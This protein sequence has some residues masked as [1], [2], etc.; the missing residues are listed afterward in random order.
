MRAREA[1]VGVF[2]TE[3]RGTSIVLSPLQLAFDEAWDAHETP[4]TSGLGARAAHTY[5]S[6]LAGRFI[7]EDSREMSFFGASTAVDRFHRPQ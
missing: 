4:A 6:I 1:A 5:E 3:P 2:P 7:D